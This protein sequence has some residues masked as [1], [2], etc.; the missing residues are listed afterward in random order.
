M[1][2]TQLLSLDWNWLVR[3]SQHSK[4]AAAHLD[5]VLTWVLGIKFRSAYLQNNCFT[6]WTIILTFKKIFTFM[7]RERRGKGW[8]KKRRS[9]LPRAGIKG[10]GC[11]LLT[12][13]AGNPNSRPL[14]GLLTTKPSLQSLSWS[15]FCVRF[16]KKYILIPVKEGLSVNLGREWR[17]AIKK[18]HLFMVSCWLPTRC[19][20]D[21]SWIF[22][23]QMIQSR[24]PR[25]HAQLTF[26]LVDSTR[27]SLQLRLAI[28]YHYNLASLS[29]RPVPA[30]C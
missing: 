8:G 15:L 2:V 14:Q 7:W 5:S 19:G 9:D 6:E 17:L 21:L 3:N 25:G 29:P 28:T 23:S 1:V 11:E 22:S 20:L 13:T 18:L 30:T 24:N 27:D 10:N 16:L 12:S 4:H 26:V